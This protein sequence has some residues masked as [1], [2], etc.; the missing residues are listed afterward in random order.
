MYRDICR[1][2]SNNSDAILMPTSLAILPCC[3]IGV[4]KRGGGFGCG[5]GST[6]SIGFQ[7]N[8][9]GLSSGM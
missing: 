7:G 8:D 4:M 5:E 3:E 1:L 6:K 2:Q 9:E